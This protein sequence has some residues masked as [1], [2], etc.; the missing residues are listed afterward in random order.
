[1]GPSRSSRRG[2]AITPQARLALCGILPLD[3]GRVAVVSLIVTL[4]DICSS[5][6]LVANRADAANL[7][8]AR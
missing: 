8:G 4:T 6:R 7:K 3:A 1:M 2:K 5:H